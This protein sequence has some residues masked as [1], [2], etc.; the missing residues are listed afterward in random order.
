[1]SQPINDVHYKEGVFVGYR[2][3]ESKKIAPLY[4][5]GHGL[6]YTSFAYEDLKLSEPVLAQGARL[7]VEFLVKNTGQVAGAEVAQ[8]YV[9]AVS[10]S[11]PRPVKELKGFSKITLAPGQSQVVRI[12]LTGAGLRVL[13]C[14]DARLARRAR[15][16]PDLRG[17]RLRQDR[18]RRKGTLR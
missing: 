9:G 6:S 18:A 14:D 8:L 12:R 17:R 2:W 16:V 10:P 7:S 15:R 13:G 5:F 4:A 3:Y 1:M 11:V